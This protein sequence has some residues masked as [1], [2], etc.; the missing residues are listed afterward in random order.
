VTIYAFPVVAL[1]S[2][3]VRITGVLLTVGTTGIAALSL[4][5]PD[6]AGLMMELGNSST[7][8]P[9]DIF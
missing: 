7:Y 2:I 3:A 6:V 1:S 8:N 5:H 4:V 9:L